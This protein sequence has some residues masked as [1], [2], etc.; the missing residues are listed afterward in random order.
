MCERCRAQVQSALR[1]GR[2]AGCGASFPLVVMPVTMAGRLQGVYSRVAGKS[3][4]RY[5]QRQS[6]FEEQSMG[7]ARPTSSRTPTFIRDMF[8]ES[9]DFVTSGQWLDSLDDEFGENNIVSV[10]LASRWKQMTKQ[11]RGLWL[12]GKLWNNASILSSINCGVLEV[13]LG[14][15]YARAVRKLKD[16][17]RK[18]LLPES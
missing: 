13:P 15:T 4:E 14:S 8:D 7:A 11:G 6:Q 9:I 17:L 12:I 2:A 1:F 18:D 5:A 3:Y 16:D 10:E